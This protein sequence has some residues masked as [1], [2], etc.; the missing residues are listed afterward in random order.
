MIAVGS[1]RRFFDGTGPYSGIAGGT[2][3]FGL[4]ML[5]AVLLSPHGWQWWLDTHQV[6]G[7]ESDGIVAYSYGG[8][9]WTIDDSKSPTRSGPRTV[10]VIAAAPN[11][12]TLQNTPTV[13]LD[14][15][16]IGGPGLIGAGLLAFGFVRRSQSRRRQVEAQR[17]GV[18][19]RLLHSFE[20]DGIV[21]ERARTAPRRSSDGPR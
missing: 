21:P 9:T 13:I 8:Q 16:V 3:V 10:Y 2:L 5:L 1:L 18:D 14:W 7:R 20:R 6:R 19:T 4:A 15:T 12:G 17:N 11:D